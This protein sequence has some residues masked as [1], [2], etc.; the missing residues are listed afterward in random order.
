MSAFI[1]STEPIIEA[2]EALQVANAVPESRVIY[3]LAAI[4][5]A[6]IILSGFES[7]RKAL[8]QI[9]WFL[10]GIL[11]GAPHSVTLPGPPGLPLVGNLT[12]VSFYGNLIQIDLTFASSWKRATS[13]RVIRFNEAA[14]RFSLIATRL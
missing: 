11:G 5:L 2:G 7:G 14:R 8:L 6:T 9:W 3:K 12:Q 13:K 4:A 10:D 1:N